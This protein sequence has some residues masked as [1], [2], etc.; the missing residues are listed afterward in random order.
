V[1]APLAS[2]V[3][4]PHGWRIERH[5]AT[6][7]TADVFV[8]QRDDGARAILKWGR[9]RDRDIHIRF[10]L[11][12]AVLRAAG[13]AWTPALYHHG[14]VSDERSESS[15]APQRPGRWEAGA[16]HSIG[17]PYIVMELLAGETLAAWM[18]RAGERGGLGEILALLDQLATGLVAI[19]AL[20]IVHRDLKPE[21]V[22]I[23]PRGVRLIDF[24]LA[25]QQA[26]LG[27]TQ[28]GA[29]VGTVHYLAPEQIRGGAL[30][31]HRADLYSFGVLAF[32]MLCGRP[33]FVGERHAIEYQ[34]TVGRPPA[35]RESRTVPEDLDRL[36]TACLAKQPEARPQS[37]AEVRAW[38]ARA[39]AASATAR[40]VAPRALGVRGR[41]ALLWIEGCEPLA[42]VRAVG[43]VNGIVVRRRGDG[44]LA[45]FT[46]LDHDMPLAAALTAARALAIDRARLVLHVGTALMR[47][48]PQGKVTAYGDDVEH[49]ARWLPAEPFAGPAGIVLT[50]AAAELTPDDAQPIPELAGFFRPGRR[51]RT[52]ASDAKLPPPLVGRSNLIESLAAVAT[53][54]MVDARPVHIAITGASGAGKSRVLAAIADRLRGAGHEV[55]ALRGQ[56]RFP[57]ERADARLAALLGGTLDAGIEQAAARGVVIALDD[58]AWLPASTIRALERVVARDA[59][60]LAVLTTSAAPVGEVDAS[61]RVDVVLPALGFDDADALIR[62]L[63]RPARL[64]PGVLIER[65]AIRATGNPGVLVALAGEITRR[66]AVRRH[67]GSDEWYVAADEL[68]TLLAAPTPAW[69]AVRALEDLPAELAALVRTCA[70]LGPRFSLDELIAVRGGDPSTQLAWLVRDGVLVDPT[71]SSAAEPLAS[72]AWYAFRDP[73]I[74][75]A[76]YD[77]VLDERAL[78]HDRAFRYWLARP[79]VDAIDR[80]A[81]LAHHGVAPHEAVTRATCLLALAHAA[82]DRGDDD[83]AEDVLDRALR[84]L[85]ADAPRLR[86]TALLARARVRHARGRHDQACNDARGARR[87]AEPVGDLEIQLDAL[88]LEATAAAAAGQPDVAT[89][90]CSAAL[91]IATADISVAVRARLLGV[92]GAGRSRDGKLDEAAA[93]LHLAAALRA[94]IGDD[95]GGDL[96]GDR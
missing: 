6:G 94:A 72:H 23:S 63:L 50:A 5:L 40:G 4:P 76:V 85:G 56:R 33:P 7:G 44:V 77:H 12:A 41:V 96:G 2:H 52:D 74:Q 26:E 17:W 61:H 43:D 89:A 65:L 39:A 49:V 48:S 9:W 13:A 53:Q 68:D 45:A 58:A 19:H 14:V 93:T 46:G 90:A 47:R 38:L 60:K 69:F 21:N 95:L 35:V 36:I 22:I 91:A 64:I 42:V 10:E 51:E 34:H 27:L 88:A 8:V 83:A 28:I 32:E 87:L 54:A 92:I 84:C 30:V 37:A 81:R 55:I 18:A 59:C 70:G 31:D 1:E 66:G 3:R 25:K 20:G 16:P 82:R 29:V 80:L 86:A 75:D 11:E 24:G 71:A 67:V 79:G 78:I 57:G 73:A 15:D 62:E